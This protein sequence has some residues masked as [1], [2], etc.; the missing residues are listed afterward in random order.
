MFQQ[1]T[2]S[3]G[4]LP[5]NEFARLDWICKS[6]TLSFQLTLAIIDFDSLEI[7]DQLMVI[8]KVFRHPAVH[9]S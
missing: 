1:V 6:L 2:G 8:V 5:V 9:K 3:N 4:F 7:G